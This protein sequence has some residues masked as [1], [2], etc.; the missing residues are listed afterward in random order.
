MNR[1]Y[2]PTAPGYIWVAKL[3]NIPIPA[4]VCPYVPY[5]S[6]HHFII[7][8]VVVLTAIPCVADIV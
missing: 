1:N 3:L 6:S 8:R 5:L 4:I 2:Q 7:A